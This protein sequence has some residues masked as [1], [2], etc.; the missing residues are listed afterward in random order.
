MKT[1]TCD[2]CGNSYTRPLKIQYM[3]ESYTFDCFE[4]AIAKLA[5]KCAACTTRVIGHGLEKG[6]EIYCCQHCL[7]KTA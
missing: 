7:D 1:A 3:Q 6:S 4:C 5:P 2:Q